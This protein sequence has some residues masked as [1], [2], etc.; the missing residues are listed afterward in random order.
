MTKED[1]LLVKEG[2]IKLDIRRLVNDINGESDDEQRNDYTIGG[3]I[4]VCVKDVNYDVTFYNIR[5]NDDT[6]VFHNNIHGN[7]ADQPFRFEVDVE[8]VGEY[9]EVPGIT[10]VRI[11]LGID[12]DDAEYCWIE[13]INDGRKFHLSDYLYPE[14]EYSFDLS[15]LHEGQLVKITII[16]N[17]DRRGRKYAHDIIDAIGLVTDIGSYHMRLTIRCNPNKNRDTVHT[18]EI[19]LC[20]DELVNE[21]IKEFKIEKIEV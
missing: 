2:D 4:R 5:A 14:K 19:Y 17:L 9:Y 8:E 7:S 1:L 10:P 21:R 3:G 15:A 20:P 16:Y 6:V 12:I 13:S 18:E 11:D